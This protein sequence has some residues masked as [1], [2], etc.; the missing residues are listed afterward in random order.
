MPKLGKYGAMV[1]TILVILYGSKLF[2]YHSGYNPIVDFWRAGKNNYRYSNFEI[3]DSEYGLTGTEY[4]ALKYVY[5]EIDS[6]ET[7]ISI[8]KRE[9]DRNLAGIFSE[10]KVLNMNLQAVSDDE[11]IL[12]EKINEMGIRYLIVPVENA[13][14]VN[15]AEKVLFENEEWKVV[16]WE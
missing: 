3:L 10:H 4:E 7:L 2:L 5:E 15:S 16:K 1:I 9:N 14:I 11:N 12:Y 13:D 6:D 8:N